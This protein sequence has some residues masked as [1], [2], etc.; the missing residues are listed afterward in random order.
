[1]PERLIRTRQPVDVRLSLG[2]L[3][4]GGG[5]D[6]CVSVGAD[7]VWRATRTAAGP[8]TI[9][10]AND[11]PCHVRARAWGPGASVALEQVPTLVGA[12]DEP[13]AL[14]PGHP[15]IA[16]LSRR[17]PGLRMGA[18]GSIFECFVP[19]VLA[20]K[21]QGAAARTAW[22][23]MVRAISEPAPGPRP[24][25]LP[26]EPARLAAT[27]SWAFHRW[28]VEHRRAETIK[29]AAGYARRLA[30][31]AS[32]PLPA[33][34]RRLGALP[35]VGPWTVN[36]VARLALG[37]ADAVSVGDYWVKHQVCWALAGEARG[38]DERMLELLEPWRGQRGRVCRLIE[39]GGP[40]LPR[41]GPRLALRAIATT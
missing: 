19:V 25:L 5:F 15:L 13:E 29:I 20:Q 17:H 12:D 35:G 9:H 3:R 28:G 8:A 32:L 4:L 26:P 33:A 1:M 10:V 21:V 18:T 16:D 24:L 22:V 34:R 38:T 6:P 2:P 7:G 36:E 39:I 40:K 11:G 37:D 41:F 27:P 30:E 31:A 23:S 14:A